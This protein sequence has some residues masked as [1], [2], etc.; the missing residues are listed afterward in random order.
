[1]GFGG[2]GEW[3]MEIPGG[4]IGVLRCWGGGGRSHMGWMRDKRGA[5][6][7]LEH[8]GGKWG[9]QGVNGRTNRGQGVGEDE[10]LGGQSRVWGGKEK[11]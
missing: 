2:V 1:M 5:D 6:E 8:W 7:C 4:Q 11:P 3:Q 9:S 10:G